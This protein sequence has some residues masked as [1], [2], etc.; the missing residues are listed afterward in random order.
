MIVSERR[1]RRIF[2][3][4]F[5]GICRDRAGEGF[6]SGRVRDAAGAL[7]L[8]CRGLIVGVAVTLFAIGG[9]APAAGAAKWTLQSTPSFPPTHA[10]NGDGGTFGAVSCT[11]ATAC[12]AVGRYYA[13]FSF[14]RRPEGFS[15][16]L[17]ETWNGH[18]WRIQST[19]TPPDNGIPLGDFNGVSC[20]SAAACI[21]VGER[22]ALPLESPLAERWD[23][24]TWMVQAVPNFP[25]AGQF[26]AVSCTSA[27]ACIA[28]GYRHA[29]NGVGAITPL[30]ERWDGQTWTLQSTAALGGMF[31]GVSCTSANAC[32]AV[33]RG[34]RVALG[35]PGGTPFAERWNGHRWML[36]S[37][38]THAR[39]LL[40]GVSCTSAR[41]CIAVGYEGGRSLAERWNGH[42]W[43]IQSTPHNASRTF[44]GVSCTSATACIAV[45]YTVGSR[46]YRSSAERW[47]G[48]NW[49]IQS[50]PN[51]A[52]SGRILAGVSCTSARAC[53]GAGSASVPGSDA[54]LAERYG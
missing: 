9:M 11:S 10:R 8:R 19:P 27:D 21:A 7:A 6:S 38:S 35:N 39:G 43:R 44:K 1:V 15:N 53:I 49:T 17:A 40:A 29:R 20:T 46:G 13:V 36:Q 16:T 31:L 12:V 34:G 25:G 2:R 3:R 45:G 37:T 24:H 22:S 41:A 23:G 4:V 47:N 51:Q 48:H 14:V 33:G 52:G 32:T 30:A 54:T 42:A 50:T 18:I 28:V 5:A 26:T